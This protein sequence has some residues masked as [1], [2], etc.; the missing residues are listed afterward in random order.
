MAGKAQIANSLEDAT[1]ALIQSEPELRAQLRD[2]ISSTIAAAKH[3]LLFGA[4]DTR[5]TLIKATM[6]GFVRAMGRVEQG[7]DEAAVREALERLSAGVTADIQRAV[8]RQAEQP[9]VP[10]PAKP[11]AARKKAAKQA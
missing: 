9:P 4:P 8:E 11:A 1:A 3:Q 5:T 6:P 7:A 2:L 10:T